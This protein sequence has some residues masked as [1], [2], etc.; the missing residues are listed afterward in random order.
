[1]VAG[2]A[3]DSFIPPYKSV[4]QSCSRPPPTA[5]GALSKGVRRRG[6][7]VG[8]GD[9]GEGSWSGRSAATCVVHHG[10]TCC[11]PTQW[12]IATRANDVSTPKKWASRSARNSVTKNVR[13]PSHT[14][15]SAVQQ[16]TSAPPPGREKR[17]PLMKFC[18]YGN[19]GGLKGLNIFGKTKIPDITTSIRDYLFIYPQMSLRLCKSVS[20]TFAALQLMFY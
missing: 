8:G 19:G 9:H 2:Y 13:E 17:S 7:G 14:I 18:V 16:Q 10:L 3:E 15:S 5:V 6:G 1:M 11:Q 4:H 20:P 12:R